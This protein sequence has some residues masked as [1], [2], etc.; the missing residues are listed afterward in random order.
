MKSGRPFSCLLSWIVRRLRMLSKRLRG[1]YDFEGEISVRNR[2]AKRGGEG[3]R[4]ARIVGRKGNLEGFSMRTPDA[5]AFM[6]RDGEEGVVRFEFP[7]NRYI[8]HLREDRIVVDNLLVLHPVITAHRH[9]VSAARFCGLH[10]VDGAWGI[11]L[12]GDVATGRLKVSREIFCGD[13]DG[14]LFGKALLSHKERFC[15]SKKRKTHPFDGRKV[16][17]VAYFDEIV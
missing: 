13:G 4:R 11:R 2:L 15:H 17:D 7:S 9:R 12:F 8:V 16:F 5:F 14:L 1:L 10:H 6:G 3:S